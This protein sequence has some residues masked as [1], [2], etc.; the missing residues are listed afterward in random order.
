MTP[1]SC[2]RASSSTSISGTSTSPTLPTTA[3]LDG[4]E[5]GRRVDPDRAGGVDERHD[6]DVNGGE[7]AMD[8]TLAVRKRGRQRGQ[9]RA[10]VRGVE[11]LDAAVDDRHR[12][13]ALRRDERVD[14]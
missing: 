1:D 11:R 10:P 7:R 5:V 13:V 2:R 14:D 9:A 4:R 8:G 12:G 6:L 3:A